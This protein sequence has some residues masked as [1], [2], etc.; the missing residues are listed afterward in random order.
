MKSVV[1]ASGY[2]ISGERYN[3]IIILYANVYDFIKKYN[4]AWPWIS[5][6]SDKVS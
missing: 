5:D 2:G 6:N 1:V 4:A 3:A